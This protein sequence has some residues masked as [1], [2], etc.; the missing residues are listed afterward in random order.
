MHDHPAIIFTA[1]LLFIFGLFSQLTE[2]SPFTGPMF[3]V[4]MG[5]LFSPLGLDMMEIHL[6]GDV[7]KLAAEV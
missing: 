1:L 7:I 6:T 4:A 2:R 5:I 3:F